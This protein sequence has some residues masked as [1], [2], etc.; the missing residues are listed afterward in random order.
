MR[1]AIIGGGISGLACAHELEYQGIYPDIFEERPRSGELFNHVAGILQ[2][3]NRP[4]KDQL[5]WLKKDYHI[6]IEPLAKWKKITM[7]SENVKRVVKS[8]KFGYFL[9]RGQSPRSLETQLYKSLKSNI[10]YNTRAKYAELAKE[11]DYVVVATGNRQIAA[12]LGVWKDIFTTMVKGAIVQGN[13]DT[14]ELIMWVNTDYALGAYGYLTPFSPTRASLVL[15]HANATVKEMERHWDTFI[16]KEHLDYHIEESFM[17]EHVAGTV[18]PHQLRNIILV[19]AAGGFMESFLGFG[20]MSSIRSGFHAAQAIAQNK[21]FTKEVR[22]LDQ[23]MRQSVRIRETLNTMDNDDYDALIRVGTLP[24]IKQIN[25][26]S[27]IPVLKYAG[28]ILEGVRHY[29]DWSKKSILPTVPS[30]NKK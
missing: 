5:R 26:H 1:V 17:L 20:T 28:N 6:E 24:I 27:N 30:Q 15:I 29:V 2:L 13:F 18:Y 23:E 25:Y 19:G 8:G 7:H 11:Y 10:Y 22:H 4:V 16:K 14:E 12:T 3:M 21:S 9:E